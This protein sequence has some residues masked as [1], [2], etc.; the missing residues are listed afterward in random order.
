MKAAQFVKHIVVG[1]S[2]L[3]ITLFFCP[4]EVRLVR[5]GDRLVI[6]RRNP[7][8]SPAAAV[9]SPVL[10]ADPYAASRFDVGVVAAAPG[11]GG[12]ADGQVELDVVGGAGVSAG[13]VLPSQLVRGVVVLDVAVPALRGRNKPFVE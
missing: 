13:L 1:A 10:F 6:A 11:T 2:L 8:T 9:G 5:S 4:I 7:F 3:P 12:L